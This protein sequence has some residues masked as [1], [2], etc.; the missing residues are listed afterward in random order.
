MFGGCAEPE[1]GGL[2]NKR[3]KRHEESFIF[4]SNIP[5][6][7]LLTPFMRPQPSVVVVAVHP[8]PQVL[9]VPCKL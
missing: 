5:K 2:E 4:I 3:P 1:E 8:S 7:V 9:D 6:G